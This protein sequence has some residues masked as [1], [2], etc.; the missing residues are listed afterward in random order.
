MELGNGERLR[1][2]PLISAP[3][4][5]VYWIVPGRGEMA[6]GNR[7]SHK[8]P[9]VPRKSDPCGFPIEADSAILGLHQPAISP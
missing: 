2:D 1:Q 5:P 7:G 8:A 4:I 3:P 9:H 6:R